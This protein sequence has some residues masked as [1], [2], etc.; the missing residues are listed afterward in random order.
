MKKILQTLVILFCATS[1]FSQSNTAVKL[2]QTTIEEYILKYATIAKN[3]MRRTGIPASI[4]LAQG[5]LE[6]NFGNS[7]LATEANNH[8]GIKCHTGYQGKGF[9]MTDD[10]ENECFRIYEKPEDSYY[11]HSEFVRL[12]P[13]YADLF[14][15]DPKDYKSWARGL[16]EA[17]YATNPQ[18]AN[19]I[20]RLIEERKI[21]QYDTADP[22]LAK[23][24]KTEDDVIKTFENKLVIFNGIKTVIAQQNQTYN[25]IADKFEVQ[26]KN[27]KKFNEFQDDDTNYYLIPGSKVF[28][29]SKK[30]KGVVLKHKVLENETMFSI[31]QKEGIL[32]NK[33]YELNLM[34]KGE[35]PAVGEELFLRSKTAQMPKLKSQKEVDKLYA[36]IKRLTIKNK[37]EVINEPTAKADSLISIDTAKNNITIEDK[38]NPIEKNNDPLDAVSSNQQ[39]PIFHIVEPKQ[40]L[41]TISLMYNI[42]SEKLVDMNDLKSTALEIGQKL[43]IG[44][45]TDKIK[46]ANDLKVKKTEREPIL[47]LVK[48]RET[49]YSIAQWYNVKPDDIKRWNNLPDFN[50]TDSMNIIVGYTQPQKPVVPVV[51]NKTIKEPIANKEDLVPVAVKEEKPVVVAETKPDIT[52]KYYTVEKEIETVDSIANKFKL[53]IGLLQKMNNTSAKQFEKGKKI[54]VGYEKQNEK[55][56]TQKVLIDSKELVIKN[57]TVAK[58]VVQEPKVEIVEEKPIIKREEEKSAIIET[59]KVEDKP[60]DIVKEETKPIAIS[61]KDID[62]PKEAPSNIIIGDAYTQY[63]TVNKGETLYAISRKYNVPVEKLIVLNKMASTGIE[64]GQKLIISIET[65][66]SVTSNN[67]LKAEEKK[68]I[69]AEVKAPVTKIETENTEPIKTRT[70]SLDQYHIVQK[71]ETLYAI[72]RMYNVPVESLIKLNKM[73]STGL[74]E[75]QKVIIRG[76]PKAINSEN[77]VATAKPTQPIKVD[78]AKIPDTKIDENVTANNPT[79]VDGIKYHTVQPGETLYRLSVIYKV[80]VEQLQ[81]WNNMKDFSI[82]LGQQY[83]VGK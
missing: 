10:A 50:L 63:H 20:I 33:L 31:S 80:K 24:L 81:Q 1:L 49:I 83:I 76:E 9:Y 78:V 45:V 35:E 3:E 65:K 4:K 46:T 54:I 16:Q 47:H 41:Y 68:P 21:H 67:E 48:P 6:S 69:I 28:L 71:N 5:I 12:R 82:K 70:E 38:A 26:Y 75:G 25:D 34:K 77:K 79:I 44:Y 14:K 55:I 59:K 37:P 61:N 51:E 56:D 15:I 39:A 62:K 22:E 8:F 40:T 13:R 19:L 60:N 43:I 36:K 32:L 7:P 18:Y 58:V 53:P 2:K 17:G 72:S 27:I 29:E 64:E 66:S 57:D 23:S 52:A 74:V 42:K 73:A 30:S 11:D